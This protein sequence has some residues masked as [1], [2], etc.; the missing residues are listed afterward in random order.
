MFWQRVLYV[1]AVLTQ[2]KRSKEAQDDFSACFNEGVL[3]KWSVST[4]S[5]V[6]QYV[7]WVGTTKFDPEN[8]NHHSS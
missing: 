5:G 8:E 2:P 6:A 7:D 3:S 1:L 4:K